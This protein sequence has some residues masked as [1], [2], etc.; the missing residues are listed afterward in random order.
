MDKIAIVTILDYDNYGNRLQN[1]ALQEFLKEF[2]SQVITLTNIPYDSVFSKRKNMIRKLKKINIEK[3]K[4]KISNKIS[5]K[6]YAAYKNERT[7]NFMEFTRRNII[8]E[9]YFNG[10]ISI[11]QQYDYFVAGSDQIWNPI[12]RNGN[13]NDFLK[14]ASAE[15][16]ISYAPSFGISKLPSEYKCEYKNLIE[17]IP[18]LSV[19]ESEG[20][21][22][23]RELTG[24]EV[25]VLLDPTFM[26]SAEK[27]GKVADQCNIELPKKY[28]LTYFLGE[29]SDLRKK[30]INEIAKQ[31]NLEIINISDLN[32]LDYYSVGPSGF[33]SL[34]RSSEVFLTDSFHGVAFS[35]IFK[36]NFV[37]F[38]R[39][40]GVPSMNS[41]INTILNTFDMK[42]RKWDLMKQEDLWISDYSNSDSI[43]ENEVQ[44]SRE[45]ISKALGRL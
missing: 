3:I 20:K 2:N 44:K 43:L 34:I 40:D 37:V 36:K 12:F 32:C 30:T 17:N 22:I 16:R 1:Y 41:R 24:R 11:N 7:N 33:L 25:D 38:E 27:W 5:S 4:V 14:F 31:K 10:N 8:E 42:S 6:K 21:E 23:I 45:F 35:I 28:L 19:R 18:F 29:T 15:K 26:V 13:S 9:R 39:E